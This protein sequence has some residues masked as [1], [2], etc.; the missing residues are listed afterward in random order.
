V[1]RLLFALLLLCVPLCCRGHE[2]DMKHF[3]ANPDESCGW[4]CLEMLLLQAGYADARGLAAEKYALWKAGKGK[5]AASKIDLA[6]ELHR[7]KVPHQVRYDLSLDQL[8]ELTKEH[9]CIVFLI[10]P[11]KG[12]AHGVLATEVTAARVKIVCPDVGAYAPRL[13]EFTADWSQSVLFLTAA[14]D[15]K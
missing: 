6:A 10:N 7:R 3:V 9:V 5:Q 2:F 14:A 4:C 12:L 1:K 13:D 8:R 11:A 15:K